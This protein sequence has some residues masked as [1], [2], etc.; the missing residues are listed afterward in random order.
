[1]IEKSNIKMFVITI[2]LGL[3]F[4]VSYITYQSA[5]AIEPVCSGGGGYMPPTCKCPSGTLQEGSIC[6]SDLS[7]SN[8]NTTKG[9]SSAVNSTQ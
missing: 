1:M 5:S 6:V 9:I 2:V 4:S 3:T 8:A 7:P